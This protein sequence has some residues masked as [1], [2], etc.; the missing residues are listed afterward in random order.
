MSNVLQN[1]ALNILTYNDCA[2]VGSN[3]IKD[4]NKQIC[5][6]NMAGRKGVCKSKF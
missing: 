4:S 1:V 6:G 3:L 2:G 5:A